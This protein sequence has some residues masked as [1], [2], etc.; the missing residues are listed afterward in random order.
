MCIFLICHRVFN[1]V[2]AMVNASE[3]NNFLS[4]W[5]KEFLMHATCI[6]SL[7]LEVRMRSCWVSVVLFRCWIILSERYR[8]T[9]DL[10]ATIQD[11]R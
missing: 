5:T 11:Y 1:V 2:L 8:W 3:A 9:R 4:H 10:Y 7:K 6:F